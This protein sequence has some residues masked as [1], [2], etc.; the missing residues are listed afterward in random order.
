MTDQPAATDRQ[1]WRDIVYTA[2]DGLRL[3]A[4]RYGPEESPLRPALCLPGL[5]RNGRDFHSLAMALASGPDARPVYCLDYRGRGLSD[6]DP[7]WRNYSPFIELLDVLD[8]MTLQGLKGASVVGT[9]RGGIIAML[10]AVMRPSAIAAA[11]LND[12]GPVIETAG[13]ARIM[14]YAGKI[15]LPR[16]WEEASAL[17]RDMNKR[18]FPQIDPDEWAEIARQ[19]FNEEK[20][21][22]APGY[23]N[24]LAKALEE[25]DVSKPMPEMWPHF[26]SLQRKPVLVLRGENSDLL[27]AKTVADMAARHPRLVAVTVRGQGHAPLLRDRFTQRVIAD[28]LRDADA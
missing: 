14:G 10:M 22:P 28:F 20:G 15:P 26:Q 11:V 8:F 6:Y 18:F 7:N 24:N 23:D 3:H 9:S 4:R 25:I 1:P 19:W 17:V 13:L 12:I 27:S 2:Q 21:R 16:S 5:T